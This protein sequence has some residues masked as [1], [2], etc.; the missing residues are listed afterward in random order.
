D[1][2]I[3]NHV[4]WPTELKRLV[5][6]RH[7]PESECKVTQIILSPK[8]FSIIFQKKSLFRVFYSAT[9]PAQSPATNRQPGGVTK[10]PPGF[11][12]FHTLIYYFFSLSFT[13]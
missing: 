5:A 8:L 4:L 10:T 13:N 9:C 12:R 11:Y 3:T 2:E 6:H 1:P 7:K